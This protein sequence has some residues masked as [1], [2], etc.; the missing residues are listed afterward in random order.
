[1]D[2]SGCFGAKCKD[3]KNQDIAAAKKCSVKQT[4]KDAPTNDDCTCFFLSHPTAPQTR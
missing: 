3:M 1:M 2:A 4:V